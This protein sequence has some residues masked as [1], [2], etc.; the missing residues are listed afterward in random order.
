[1]NFANKLCE[2]LQIGLFV[3]MQQ[4][5]RIDE[6]LE[7]RGIKHKWLCEQLDVSSGT[8]SKWCSNTSQPRLQML[9][10]IARVLEVRVCELLVEE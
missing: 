2:S 5:N 8:V 1:M 3:S 7:K 10:R 6:V 9:F 4:Y